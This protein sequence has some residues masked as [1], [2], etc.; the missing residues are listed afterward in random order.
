[1]DEELTD[2]ENEEEEQQK[3]SSNLDE[4]IEAQSD[5]TSKLGIG[6]SEPCCSSSIMDNTSSNTSSGETESASTTSGP[7]VE[8]VVSA[9]DKELTPCDQ[10]GQSTPNHE[11][12][13][14]MHHTSW[15]IYYSLYLSFTS[16][17][18]PLQL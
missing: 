6:D 12:R 8:T 2:S 13:R 3:G 9:D 10:D 16:A 17:N 11:V 5:G 18:R 15:L 7:K 1:M 4:V 14:G